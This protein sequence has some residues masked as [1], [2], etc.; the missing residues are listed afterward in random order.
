MAARITLRSSLPCRCSSIVFLP[1]SDGQLSPGQKTCSAYDDEVHRADT[2][3]M[4]RLLDGDLGDVVCG[5]EDMDIGL[6][7]LTDHR[8]A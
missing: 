7:S 6:K 8:A 3:Q 5:S 1:G 2:A 4:P